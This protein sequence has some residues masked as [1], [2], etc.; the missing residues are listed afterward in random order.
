MRRALLVLAASLVTSGFAGAARAQSEPPRPASIEAAGD[1]V[2]LARAGSFDP[3]VA[4]FDCSDPADVFAAE[5]TGATPL[6][7]GVLALRSDAATTAVDALLIRIAL[8]SDAALGG[9]RLGLRDATG[10]E[11]GSAELAPLAAVLGAIVRF[12]APLSTLATGPG[13]LLA[14]IRFEFLGMAAGAAR[15]DV[16]GVDGEG[17]VTGGG[18]N[19]ATYDP[20]SGLA[21]P[22]VP[23]PGALALGVIGAAALVAAQRRRAGR[24]RARPQAQARD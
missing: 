4:A 17:A 14:L 15:I 24:G 19:Y 21:L 7:E 20:A 9:V 23:E 1:W 8:S 2:D 11:V 16:L 18:R 3:I 6:P 5:G 22:P 12:D 13:A 10:A